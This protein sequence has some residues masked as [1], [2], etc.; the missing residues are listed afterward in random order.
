MMAAHPYERCREDLAHA[1]ILY[2]LP[3][4]HEPLPLLDYIGAQ[5][6]IWS[7][8]RYVCGPQLQMIVDVVTTLR[9]EYEFWAV[10]TASQRRPGRIWE[11]VWGS[12]AMRWRGIETVSDL[13]ELAADY[14]RECERRRWAKRAVQSRVANRSRALAGGVR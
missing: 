6:R 9:G 5:D 3:R 12:P 2:A 10:P 14:H 1:I 11:I 8:W 7:G 13:L 4:F